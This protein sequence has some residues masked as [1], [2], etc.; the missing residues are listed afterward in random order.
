MIDDEKRKSIAKRALLECSGGEESLWAF[1]N[2]PQVKLA[3]LSKSLVNTISVVD[4]YDTDQLIQEAV[5]DLGLM[6]KL[7]INGIGFLKKRNQI[8]KYQN[9]LSCIDEIAVNLRIRQAQILKDIVILD[10]LKEQITECSKELSIYIEVGEAYI[11]H[12]RTDDTSLDTT[13]SEQEE[14]YWRR[15][16]KKLNDLKTTSV[17]VQQSIVQIDIMRNNN[18]MLAE[19]M[20]TSLSTT[21]PLWRSQTAL[22]FGIDVYS[23]TNDLQRDV[24]LSAEKMIKENRKKISKKVKRIERKSIEEVDV[25][26]L[27]E[28]NNGL[29]TVLQR[30]EDI[31]QETRQCNM[32]MNDIVQNLQQKTFSEI[33]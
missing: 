23:E 1:G 29:S 19:K 2:D 33:N 14:R 15:F 27:K 20:A 12:N 30:I 13:V 4:A 18:Q 28:L 3:E 24:L 22:M 25:E 7:D 31:G 26:K 6:N 21:I 5:D 11:E 10:R 8:K 32:D 17:I 16:D 9:A